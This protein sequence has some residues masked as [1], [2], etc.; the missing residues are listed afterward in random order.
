MKKSLFVALSLAVTTTLGLSMPDPR[1]TITLPITLASSDSIHQ[2]TVPTPI[3]AGSYS[4]DLTDI[5]ITN[6]EGQNVPMA[7]I[8]VD[9]SLK[10]LSHTLKA[11]ALTQTAI[12]NNDYTQIQLNN[13]DISITTNKVNTSSSTVV[14]ALLD[15][16]ALPAGEYTVGLT[17]D[18]QTPAGQIVPLTIERS[19]DLNQWQPLA[20]TA[21]VQLPDNPPTTRI[22][23]PATDVHGQYLRISWTESNAVTLT[24]ATLINQTTQQATTQKI[25]LHPTPADSGALAAYLP[26]VLQHHPSKLTLHTETNNI[27]V[28][29]NIGFRDKYQETYGDTVKPAAQTVLFRLTQNG[30]TFTNS[31]INLSVPKDKNTLTLAAPK[32]QQLPS[33]LKASIELPIRRIAFIA[34]GSAPYTLRYKNDTNP[35][36]RPIASLLPNYQTGDADKL[37]LASISAESVTTAFNTHP[38]LINAAQHADQST[39]RKNYW[40]WGVLIGGVLLLTGMVLVIMKQ[41]NKKQN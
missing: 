20:E 17:L 25:D 13:S 19:T 39:S 18:I 37:P 30:Q 10:Q 4:P 2:L 28:P 32:G 40:L 31:G 1:L 29:V 14:G 12:S 3:V 22:D 8:P 27:N 36:A 21:A 26:A 9:A 34:S 33:D 24:N 7:W 16:R 11:R 38:E 5:V 15:A 41:L 6:A 23:I 35:T